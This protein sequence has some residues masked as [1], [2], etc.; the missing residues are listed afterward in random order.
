MNLEQL[1]KKMRLLQKQL[2]DYMGKGGFDRIHLFC[3]NL[4]YEHIQFI[5]Y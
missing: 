5:Q 4:N 2:A 3:I 1:N